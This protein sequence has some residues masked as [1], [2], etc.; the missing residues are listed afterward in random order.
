MDIR[1]LSLKYFNLNVLIQFKPGSESCA[2]H[3]KFLQGVLIER[4][5]G[6]G[7]VSNSKPIFETNSSVVA[8]KIKTKND[9]VGFPCEDV[10]TISL[11]DENVAVKEDSSK[12]D[13]ATSMN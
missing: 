4:T 5:W 7:L 9:Q 3:G 10:E 12:R 8:L 2:K 1:I 13:T 11:L 6:E